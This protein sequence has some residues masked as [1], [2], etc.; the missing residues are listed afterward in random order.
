M[1]V[2]ISVI[3]PVLNEEKLL[4]A[5]LEQFPGDLLERFSMEIL[6]SDGGSSDRT[7]EIA[8]EYTGV[9]V[10]DASGTRTISHGRNAGAARA[11]GAIL[12]FLNADVRLSDP[13][14]FFNEIK[15]GLIR[16]GVAAMTARV[17]VFPEEERLIDRLF[18]IVHNAYC[19]LLNAIGEGM[20]RGECQ[21]LKADMFREVGGYNDTMA[22]GEDFDLFRRVRKHGTIRFIPAVTVYESPRRFRKY[23]Y[24]RI[25]RD[26]TQ[27]ALSVMIKNKSSS[28]S[29]DPVR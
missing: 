11:G 13:V 2:E 8:G 27:N 6:V 17:H 18:H 21:V 3:V 22:A 24:L 12:V 26:W 15:T 19:R 5:F 10:V 16:P 4:P 29:W 9:H 28:K 14:R 1:S 20:G 7:R 23:G 25:V